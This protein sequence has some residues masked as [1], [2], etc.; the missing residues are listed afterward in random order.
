MVLWW[1]P[2]LIMLYND[3]WQPILGETKHPAGLGRPGAECWPETWPIVRRQFEDALNGKANW[4]E[5]L[6]LASDRHGFLE[7]CYFTY[8]HSPL[9]DAEGKVVGVQ[10]AVIETTDRVLSERR[11]LI[12]RDLSKA[13]VEAASQG[14]SVEHTCEAILGLLCNGNFDIPFA[15]QYIS[16]GGTRAR[17]I[18]SSGINRSHLP[19]TITAID[20]DPWGTAQALRERAPAVSQHPRGISEPLPGGM[21]PEPTRQV[22]ALPLARKGPTSDLLGVLLVGVNSRLSLDQPYMD[23]LNL[24]AAEVAGSIST[25]QDVKK[26]RKNHAALREAEI[27]LRASEARSRAQ[28]AQLRA[29]SDEL[30]TTLNTA[31]IG[32]A[33]CSRDLCYLRANETYATIVG[34]SLGE[35]IGRPIVEVIG[36]AAFNTIRPYIERV[37]AGERVEFERVVPHHRGAKSSYFRVVNVPDRGPDGFVIGWI[38]CVADIT[39]SKQAERR[40]AERNA[41]LDLA[42]AIARTGHFTYDHATRKLQLSPGC[43]AIYGLPE[44]TLEIAKVVW[45]A[46]VHPDDLPRVDA[47]VGRALANGE[48]EV[49]VDFRI[50]RHG[51]VRWIE[52]RSLISYNEAGRS[53]RRMGAKIDV[54]ERKRA[55]LALEASEAKFA[56]ILEIAGDA[57]LSIDADSRIRLFNAAAERLFGYSRGEILGQPIDLLIPARSRAAHQQHIARFASGPCIPRR[58]AEQQEVAGRRKNGDEFPAEASISK[59]EVGGEW[60]YTVVLRD[61]SERKRAQERQ[62]ALAAELDHRVKNA[63]ATVSAVVSHTRQGST[64]L[65]NFAAALDGRIRSMAT[66]HELLSF[67][68]WQGVSL[69]ELVQ[70][71]LAPYAARNNTEISGAEVILRPEAGQAMA[72]VLHELATNAAKYGALS[73]KN[74]RV[75]IWWDQHL[76]GCLRSHLVFE[77]QEIG[78]PSVVAL[79]RPSY[80]TNTIRELIPYEFG[81]TVD[82][83]LAPEGVRCRLELPADWLC[84]DRRTFSETTALASPRS[85]RA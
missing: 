73:S 47:I 63:L 72:M 37:L 51:E 31:G 19:A 4:S 23:F 58:M 76:N 32:I 59:V 75:T 10:T 24:I 17:L 41:Q 61:I 66:T 49:V 71:E 79:G 38:T 25:I 78:G 69:R 52:S 3:A 13:M 84:N 50:V 5:N 55:E 53:V 80:G 27:A 18:C 40:L 26:E 68:R 82:F 56:G 42:G 64:S 43:T 14:K 83:V 11:M 44:G 12:L 21:W 39:A 77:W 28:A 34:L 1:G 16:E 2:D 7:E 15:A 60:I 67:G 46:L 85:R 70:R 33:R 36:E 22:V 9:R 29:L 81:G 54:T 57:I 30:S 35:I 45:R 48:T 65:A 20:R 6:L 8:S 74:G 62:H